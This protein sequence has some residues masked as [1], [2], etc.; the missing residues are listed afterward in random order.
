MRLVFTLLHRWIGLT[1]AAFLIVSG[2]TGAVISWDHELDEWL[3]PNLNE[4]KST[5]ESKPALELVKQVEARDPRI[6]VLYFPLLAEPGES[7]ALFVGPRPDPQTSRLYEVDYNQVFLDPVTGAELGRRLWGQAWPVTRETLVSFLYRLHYTLHIPELWSNDRIGLWLMGA[8][9]LVWALDCFIGFYLTLPLRHAPN[10]GR[11]AAV[12]RELRKGWW[13]R[14][15]PSWRIKTR[16][17]TY[18]INFDIHRAFGLWTWLLLFILAFTGFSLNL[19]REIFL[20]AMSMIS[21]VTP[22]VFETRPPVNKHSPIAPRLGYSEV[23]EL[24]DDEGRIRG[25][26]EP[27]GALFYVPLWG[28]YGAMYFAGNPHGASGVGP[29]RVYFDAQDGRVLGDR[30]PWS[31]TAADIFV[32]AQFPL[33]SGRILGMPGRILISLMGVVVTVLTITGVVIWY[34]KRRVRVRR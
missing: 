26:Q 13:A 17:S 11:P 27:V 22:T 21:N 29:A 1:I 30:I 28:V 14:W 6:A 10:A 7:L 18:R 25:W 24:A 9:A 12:E 23:L 16:G 8:V 2:T 19:Y 32:Q 15:K 34:R 20:P 33:H 31:G 3:N 5:G 4:V